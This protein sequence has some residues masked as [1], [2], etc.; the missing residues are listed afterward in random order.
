VDF[1]SGSQHRDRLRLPRGRPWWR[2]GRD[3]R[4]YFDQPVPVIDRRA[5]TG[6]PRGTASPTQAAF[7]GRS[8]PAPRRRTRSAALHAHLKATDAATVSAGQRPTLSGIEQTSPAF[9]A[10]HRPQNDEGRW[11]AT[12]TRAAPDPSRTSPTRAH[13]HWSC[14]LRGSQWAQ[15]PATLEGTTANRCHSPVTPF[16]L[17]VPRSSN[18][19]P[20]PATSSLT[21]LETTTSLGPAVAAIRAPTDSRSATGWRRSP[22]C[23]AGAPSGRSGA[24]PGRALP[25]L[26]VVVIRVRRGRASDESRHPPFKSPD[27]SVELMGDGSIRY[28]GTAGVQGAPAGCPQMAHGG[29]FAFS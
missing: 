7:T 14:H 3:V 19:S 28:A 18:R 21:M 16:R 15:S 20:D 26:T 9:R 4:L 25:D 10:A 27:P 29:F 17:C 11:E 2:G 24:V 12:R 8:A 1:R 5:A 13:V 22:G 6:F 23:W